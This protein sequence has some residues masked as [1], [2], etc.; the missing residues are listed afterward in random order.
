MKPLFSDSLLAD[1]R[2]EVAAEVERHYGNLGTGVCIQFAAHAQRAFRRRGYEPIIQAGSCAWRA[3]ALDQPNTDAD[4]A[5]FG[6]EWSPSDIRSVA[7]VYAGAMPEM[8]VWLGFRSNGDWL[9]DFTACLF[10][11]QRVKI[12]DKPWTGPL[13]PEVYF[14]QARRRFG[15]LE[16]EGE[17]C[18]Y[19]PELQA[20]VFTHL[21]VKDH[22]HGNRLDTR[23]LDADRIFRFLAAIQARFPEP[24]GDTNE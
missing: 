4:P 19:R 18:W 16:E 8:H 17:L 12:T 14:A 22:W 10:P 11:A 2:A 5:Y 21:L 24:R 13:P 15:P 1:V 3:T 7:S 6:Y 20:C 23:T 9:L